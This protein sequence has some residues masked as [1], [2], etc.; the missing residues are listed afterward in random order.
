[1]SRP[2]VAARAALATVLAVALAALAFGARA[3]GMPARDPVVH[4]ALAS[5]GPIGRVA[6]DGTWTVT[7]GGVTRR[8]K[9]PYSPNAAVVSGAAGQRSFEGDVATYRTTIDAPADG[10]YAIR[11][12]SVNHRARVYLDG[13]LFAEHVGAYLPFEA[14]AHLAAGSH[15]LVVRA[16]WRSPE[17]MTARGWHR[18]WFNF[19]GIGREV[20]IRPLGASEVDAPG[21]VTRLRAGGAAVVDVT[22]RVTNHAGPRTLRVQGR[23]GSRALRFAPVA[24]ERNA[25]TTVHAR[26]RIAKPNL[27]APGHP[28][29][30]TLQLSVA[31]DAVGGWRARVGLREVR[32]AGGRLLLNGKP[33]VLRGASLQEDAPG[34]GDALTSQDMDAVVERLQALGANATRSQHALNPALLE[35]LDAAGIL[36]W[37]GIG[38]VDSPGAWTGTTP[39]LRRQGLRRVRIDLVEARTHPSVLAWNLANEVANNGHAGGQAQFID[40]AAQLAHRLDPGRPVAVDVWGTHMPA[41]AGFM[42][43]HVDAIGGTNYEGWYEDVRAPAAVV[44]RKIGAWLARFR[45]AFPG[46][47]LAVTEFGAEANTHNPS[48][49]PGGLAFQTQLL[50][51]HIRIYGAQPWLAG[52]LVWNV[53]DFALSPDFEGGSI[54]RLAP[55][56]V[57]E[58]GINQKGLFTYG[59]RPKPAA[60]VVRRLYAEAR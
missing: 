38:P 32:W 8:V 42:Y 39:V 5:G 20:T 59:G 49:G 14:R 28:A 50:A 40:S 9:L 43:R 56:M 41:R 3:G 6:L 47:V 24:L 19:G 33:I 13:R 21:I 29:L 58:R 17:A 52:M 1:M 60:A 4:A 55:E 15:T 7:S 34:R 44:E 45:A 16:D 51:R 35:R 2:T 18:V 53:Q 36:V 22:A 31:G 12:E 25:T 48:A 26:L 10:D 37:Q 57:L 54:R 30:Q 23:L 27:W 11:F 46:R